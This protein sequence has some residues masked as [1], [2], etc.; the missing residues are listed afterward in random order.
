MLNCINKYVKSAKDFFNGEHFEI[1]MNL[2]GAGLLNDIIDEN[3]RKEII[4]INILDMVTEEDILTAVKNANGFN[5]SLFVSQKAFETLCKHMINKLKP[6]SLDCA[7]TVAHELKRMFQSIKTQ[8]SCFKKLELEI[9]DTIKELINER[10]S[11]KKVFIQQ[12]FEVET[13]YINTRHPDFLDA[14]TKSIIKNNNDSERE[15]EL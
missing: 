5:P 12:F 2:T 14:A 4:G 1:G 11:P 15:T 3:F 10:L 13:G 9:I 7:E 8:L 6:I